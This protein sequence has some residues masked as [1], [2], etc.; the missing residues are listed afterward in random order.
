MRGAEGGAPS[1]G[2]ERRGKANRHAARA[3]DAA[4]AN[5]ACVGWRRGVG[6]GFPRGEGLV[7]LCAHAALGCER[8]GAS[9]G[10]SRRDARKRRVDL[11]STRS[12]SSSRHL[13]A[14]R[15]P[16]SFHLPPRGKE[17]M[18]RARSRPGDKPPL[19]CFYTPSLPSTSATIAPSSAA[20]KA[21]WAPN[22]T[23][24]AGG[25]C[26]NSAVRRCCLCDSP[27][28]R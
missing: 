13:R 26:T 21:A 25:T 9:R 16:F 3:S 7:R 17:R 28:L 14:P 11:L 15:R 10:Y 24:S 23:T 22:P 5:G 20:K 6:V 12:L 27:R 1:G 2:A 18:R 4:S 19:F 8:G